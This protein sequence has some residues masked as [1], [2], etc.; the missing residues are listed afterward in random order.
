MQLR[1]MLVYG[2]KSI[3]PSHGADWLAPEINA[4]RLE[5]PAR[6]PSFARP[7]VLC[8]SY[9]LLTHATTPDT[10]AATIHVQAMTGPPS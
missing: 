9:G 1:Y 2:V 3:D 10:S 5:I 8:T 7:Q 6:P 4:L